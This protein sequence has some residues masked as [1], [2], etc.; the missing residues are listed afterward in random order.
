GGPEE[1]IAGLVFQ[2]KGE[3]S[4][5]VYFVLAIEEAE[6]FV[7]EMTQDKNMQIMRD[8]SVDEFSASVLQ[9]TANILTGSYLSAL[10]DFTTLHMSTTVPYLSIDMAAA[11]LVTGLVEISQVTDYALVIDTKIKSS[12]ETHGAKGHFL[13]IPDP[14]SIPT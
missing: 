3:I 9:K 12:D 5:S 2:I 10:S 7:R 4:G 14:S 11:T 8:D 1:I 6:Y 13:L